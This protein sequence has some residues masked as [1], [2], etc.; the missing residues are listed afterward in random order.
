MCTYVLCALGFNADDSAK[1]MFEAFGPGSPFDDPGPSKYYKSMKD[2]SMYPIEGKWQ[3][4]LLRRFCECRAAGKTVGDL[5]EEDKNVD[6]DNI[7]RLVPL[8]AFYAGRPDML[9]Q[10]ENAA[11]QLQT[12]DMGL[13]IVLAACRLIECFIQ[14]SRPDVVDPQS[15][16]AL[17]TSVIRDLRSPK[18]LHP[19]PLDLAVSGHLQAAVDCYDLPIAEAT[20]RLGHD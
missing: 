15:I 12:A 1:R 17:V 20:K 5:P 2:K 3:N 18:R 7:P 10:A 13:A 11:V 9:E 14:T 16:Q 19:Q 8:V 4:F 6:P